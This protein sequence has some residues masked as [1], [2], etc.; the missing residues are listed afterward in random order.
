L[1]DEDGAKIFVWLTDGTQ[2]QG[3]PMLHPRLAALS[4]RFG[5]MSSSR[6]Y[7]QYS[8]MVAAVSIL[9]VN[10]AGQK[11]WL[12]SPIQPESVIQTH[13]IFLHRIQG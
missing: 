10:Q 3:E 8:S 11:S 1:K 4:D 5:R 2:K 12:P 7:T 9:P 6:I 13:P